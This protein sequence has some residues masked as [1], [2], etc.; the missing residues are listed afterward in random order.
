MVAAH[1]TVNHD[2][3]RRWAEERGG[4]PAKVRGTGTN[5]D[6]GML[7]IDFPG[8]SSEETLEKID[9]GDWLAAFDE[10]G[11][12]FLYQDETEDGQVSRFNKLVSLDDN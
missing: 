9:W 10:N 2:E 1:T 12:A 6:P 5:G 4:R 3:I 7:R 11:L 8:C